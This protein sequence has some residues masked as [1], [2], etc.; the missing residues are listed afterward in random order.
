MSQADLHPAKQRR[1]A[2]LVSRQVRQEGG[3]D[4][5]GSHWR[6]QH[7]DEGVTIQRLNHLFL[8]LRLGLD[9]DAASGLDGGRAEAESLNAPKGASRDDRSADQSGGHFDQSEAES[10]SRDDLKR[11][12]GGILKHLHLV[13]KNEGRSRVRISPGTQTQCLVFH[14]CKKRK[15]RTPASSLHCPSREIGDQIL[16]RKLPRD[17]AFINAKLVGIVLCYK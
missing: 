5:G 3:H 12:R 8:V 11:T 2:C 17:V 9:L 10:K 13:V 4:R 6:L 16:E 14:R 7:P 1:D 15:V